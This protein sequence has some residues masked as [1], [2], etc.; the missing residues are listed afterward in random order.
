MAGDDVVGDVALGLEI[1]VE[2]GVL[3]AH[4]LEVRLENCVAGEGLGV[5]TA[6]LAE[7]HGH[8]FAF[9]LKSGD[10]LVERLHFIF[11]GPGRELGAER[12][13]IGFRRVELGLDGI[14]L[15]G[16]LADAGGVAG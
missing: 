15:A 4:H 8:G 11:N 12:F 5:G 14:A 13:G 10:A 9:L 6:A 1:A 3:L 7:R 2:I 16:D